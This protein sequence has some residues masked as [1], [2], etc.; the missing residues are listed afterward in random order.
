MGLFVHLCGSLQ[1]VRCNE[2]TDACIQTKL[3]RT[4]ADNSM[5]CYRVGDSEVLDGLEEFVPLYPWQEGTP[6]VAGAG[7]W[8]C[9]SC[10]LNW[11]WAK[12]TFHV[13]KENDQWIATLREI[14]DLRPGEADA[15]LGIHYLEPDLAE[16]TGLWVTGPGYNW[17]EG[18]RLWREC[19]IGERCARIAAGY[20]AWCEEVAGVDSDA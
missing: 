2:T 1:C 16:L 18:C 19:T 3:L 15:L 9:E 11:Q 20:R 4:D 12:A 8:A 6:L 17:E 7:D 14:V 13:V 10:G 5:R